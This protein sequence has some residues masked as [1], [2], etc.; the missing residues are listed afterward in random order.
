MQRLLER[1]RQ[2]VSPTAVVEQPSARP[3]ESQAAPAEATTGAVEKPAPKPREIMRAPETPA[4]MAKMRDL[5][6]DSVRSALHQFSRQRLLQSMTSGALVTGVGLVAL[7]LVIILSPAE[8]RMRPW[9]I[10][11]L[12]FVPIVWGLR[13]ALLHRQ[14]QQRD[15]RKSQHGNKPGTAALEASATGATKAVGAELVQAELAPA[16]VVKTTQA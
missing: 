15:A 14:L 2:G 8:S 11:T 1:S 12:T 4:D 6:N 5:A 9:M 7:A 16:T 13:T 10:A 3:K